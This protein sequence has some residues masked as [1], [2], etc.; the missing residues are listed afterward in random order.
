VTG[1]DFEHNGYDRRVPA[2][3][4]PAETGA[5]MAQTAEHADPVTA[6][7][8]HTAHSEPASRLVRAG[9]VG[10]AFV[11]LALALAV[12]A[13]VAGQLSLLVIPL[14]IALFPAALLAPVADWLKE[15]RVPAAAASLLCILGSLALLAGVVALLVPVVAGQVPDLVD[16]F[17]EGVGEFEQFLQDGP[18]PIE[19]E[20]V[21]ELIERGRE[22][23]TEANGELAGGAMS[24]ATT[25]MEG[26]IGIVFG[27]VVLFFYLK[28]GP[29]IASGI[30]DTFPRQMRPHVHEVGGR[31]WWTLGSYFRGQL[32][33]ALV[34][35]IF[36]GIGL[37]LLGVPLAL[38]LAV[39]VFFGGLFPIV[40]AFVSGGVAVLVALADGGF[41][42]ALAVLA[43]IVVVQQLES[44]VLEPII[45]SRAISLHPL[46]VL[47]A[48]TAGA[49]T[50]GI[51]G[52]FL[53]VP[54]AAGFARALDYLRG[55]TDEAPAAA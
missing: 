26:A 32:L 16:S 47:V 37:L 29:R 11:G 18:L 20:G 42:V 55:R 4:R 13:L 17:G 50:L 1:P 43:L 40:G 24:A 34:D 38:P 49:V 33:V 27:L 6:Q 52:A 21:D 7:P 14:I 8:P 28:D 36:I 48:I 45:L 22:Q 15:H 41:G 30:R 2:A 12:V 51:L 54:V 53:A 23:L 46:M 35:A 9:R 19:V 25:A 3:T 5:Q 44:N 39:L 31:V 10:W